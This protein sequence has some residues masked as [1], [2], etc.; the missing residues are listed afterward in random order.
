MLMPEPP[1][2][3]LCASLPPP[4]RTR[5][6][7]H[8]CRGAAAILL[9]PILPAAAEAADQTLQLEAHING[10]VGGKI[11]EFT[12]HDSTLMA[13]PRELSD[14]GLRVPEERKSE[15]LIA[16]SDLPGVTWRF[17]E[18]GQALYITIPD[19]GLIPTQLTPQPQFDTVYTVESGLGM[20]LN[21]DI[22]GTANDG[23]Y[24]GSGISDL[25]A[26]SPWGVANTGFL[27]YAGQTAT[28]ARSTIRLDSIY[29]YSDP[30]ALRRYRLGDFINGGLAWSRPIRMGGLQISSD[31]ALRPDMVTFPLPSLSG[32]AAVP[33]TVDVLTNGTKV[34]SGQVAAGPFELQQLP[35]VT[36]AGTVSMTV[37][38]ALGQQ[39]ITTLPFYASAALLAPGLQ[40]YSAQLGFL[41]QNYGL[42]SNNYNMLAASAAYRRGVS[43]WLTVE[44]SAEAASGM[45]MSGGGAAINL[46]NFAVLNAD[47]AVSVNSDRTGVQI[48]VGLQ[49]IDPV[50]SFGVS[51][52]SASHDFRDIAAMN[53]EPVP[54]L[55]LNASIG[56]SLAQFGSIGFAYA[57]I[58]RD[59]TS[60]LITLFEPS[61]N[62]LDQSSSLQSKALG[63]E[64]TERASILSASYSIQVN[65]MS[66]YATGFRDFAN[67]NNSGIMIGVTIPLGA[68]SSAD[69]SGGQGTSGG[70][71]QFHVTQ[72][73]ELP[74]DW[75]YDAYGSSG[76]GEHEFGLVQ[77]RAPWSLLTAGID[78][79]G[80]QISLRGEAQGAIS[81]I[82]GRLF[83][84]TPI[85]D[86]FAIVDTDGV[87]NVRVQ[88]ENRYVGTTDTTGHLI[89]PDLRAFDINRIAIDPTDIPADTTMNTPA[90]TVRPQDRSGVIVRFPAKISHGALLQLTDKSGAPLPVGSTATLRATGAIAPIGYDGKT[91]VTDL[92]TRNEILVERPDGQRCS[93]LFDYRPSPGEIPQIGPLLCQDQA[94]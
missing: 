51:M 31:F 88:Q 29:T 37:T 5:T 15:T 43:S 33:S 73:A 70:Y 64:P 57:E 87:S 28:R 63:F 50:F 23:R 26:F 1:L 94:S 66:L 6:L 2:T 49:R 7:Q 42:F 36:G 47:G 79:T 18:A 92:G 74:G 59:S 86:S 45:V 38:N 52:T 17:D 75:G 11:G 20:T 68:R 85:N 30:D 27:T 76:N 91:Y 13:R 25:R 40:D 69:V 93:V 84:S 12:L 77:Y 8:V 24:S 10:Y 39:V 56:L 34:L 72:S 67:R 90:R 44:A 89:V 19:S 55:Q 14:L 62:V 16:L 60:S 41:R 65:K 83:A 53:G 71:G 4:N 35:V 81:F 48:S 9:I 80:R 46:G 32:S 3:K 21:Y 78:H 61:S 22:L 58:R 54:R 82:D